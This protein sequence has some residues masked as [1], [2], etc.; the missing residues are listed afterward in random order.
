M[1]RERTEIAGFAAPTQQDAP[2]HGNALPVLIATLS[3]FLS[4][5]IVLTAVTVS[6]ARAGQLF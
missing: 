1:C 4:I 3:L 5:A 6:A 2:R